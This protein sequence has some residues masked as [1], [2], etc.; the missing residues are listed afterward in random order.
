MTSSVCAKIAVIQAL[1]KM[2]HQR[3]DVFEKAARF[4]QLEPVW[5]GTEDSAP[6]LRAA[7]IIALA[8][9]V[10]SSSLP[11]LVNAMLDPSRDVRIATAQALGYIGNESAGLVLR[12]KARTGDRDPDVLSECFSGLLEVDPHANLSFVSEYLDEDQPA[13]CEAAALALGKSRLPEAL[14]QLGACWQ[15]CGPSETGRQ[16]LLAIAMLRLPAAIDYLLEL[17]AS[18]SEKEASAAMSALEIHNYDPRLRERLAQIVLKANHRTLQ[19]QFD[20]DFRSD[21]A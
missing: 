1:D 17:V 9:I 8:R 12:F 7:A 4:V 13:Q 16:V 11:L 21:E 6:P 20:R 14:A 3:P 18:D 15:R 5:G 10:G 2:E 19:A